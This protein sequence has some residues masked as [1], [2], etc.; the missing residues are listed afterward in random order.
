M[1]EQKT[2]IIVGVGVAAAGLVL[3]IARGAKA[4]PP[5]KPGEGT[6][7]IVIIGPDGQPV[8]QV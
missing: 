2:G 3:L 8:P 7:D 6:I 4:A 5:D 1:A